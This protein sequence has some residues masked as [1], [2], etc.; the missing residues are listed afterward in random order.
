MALAGK[1]TQE[2]TAHYRARFVNFAPDF[3][4]QNRWWTCA[5]LG[6][7]THGGT[8]D[9][10]ADRRCVTAIVEAVLAGANVIDTAINYRGMRSE[11]AV[12]VALSHLASKKIDRSEIVV[13]TKGGFIPWEYESLQ[14]PR[15]HIE[16]RYVRTRICRADDIVDGKHCLAPRFL[17]DQIMQS[18]AKLG[19][20]TI[21][22]YF[23]HNPEFQLTEISRAALRSRLAA[24]FEILEEE[25]RMGRI[26]IY[27]VATWTGLR[28]PV[29]S[30]DFLDLD[31]L[32]GI[33]ESVA[34]ADHRFRAVQLPFSLAMPEALL[35][36]NQC[37]GDRVSVLE[38]CK[39]R[40]L[41]T[42][43]SVP[44][45]Q[46]RLSTFSSRSLSRLFAGIDTSAQAALQFARSAVGVTTALVGMTSERHIQENLTLA[47]IPCAGA[48]I[49]GMFEPEATEETR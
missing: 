30:R 29:N 31:E 18:L 42:F 33:A 24:A 45:A 41:I 35:I 21:D 34:G 23:L 20:Q 19:L 8:L 44:L 5:S 22:V 13:A 28:V 12:A 9:D 11:P 7:G 4:R 2:G 25:A 40:N 36:R 37:S 3:F 32:I 15:G 49:L 27:G 43:T 14:N 26:Q 48:E 16:A 38:F 39:A 46:G 17:Q 47:R 6:I 10:H 1:A